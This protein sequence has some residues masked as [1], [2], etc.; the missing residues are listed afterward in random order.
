M[1][2]SFFSNSRTPLP[3]KMIL[4]GFDIRK[5][6][7]SIKIAASTRKS[8]NKYKITQSQLYDCS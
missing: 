8:P 2:K 5:C 4:L 3:V 7:A 1:D 6:I